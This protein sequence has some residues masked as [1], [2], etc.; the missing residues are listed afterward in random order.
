MT[1]LWGIISFLICIILGIAVSYA[2][3][4]LT[5]FISN[6]T[7]TIDIGVCVVGFIVMYILLGLLDWIDSDSAVNLAA[8]FITALWSLS[9]LYGKNKKKGA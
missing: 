6:K 9:D 5:S 1:I 4:Y 8:L 2:Y 7:T 3:V